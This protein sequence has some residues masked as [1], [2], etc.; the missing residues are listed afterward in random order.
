[1]RDYSTLSYWLETAGDDLTPRPA[2]DR[3]LDADVA[4]LGA[5]F[6]GLWTAYYLLKSRPGL[7]VVVLEKEIAGFGASG[8]NGGWCSSKLN[9][10][11]DVV[12]GRFGTAAAQGL[13]RALFDTVD[14]VGRAC[15]AEG[16]DAAYTKGGSLFV[17]RHPYQI[18]MLHEWSGMHQTFGFGDRQQ[19]L[20]AAAL[21]ERIRIQG[22]IAAWYS[23]D[24][25]SVHPGR[26]VRGL[27]RTVER[28]GGR[29]FERTEVADYRPG[30]GA[31]LSTAGGTVRAGAIV[32]AGE[33]Y[34]TRLRRL[35]R[36]L[37]PIYS[38]IVLTEPLSERQWEAIGWRAR[39]SVASFRL[40]VDYL[41][42]TPDGRIL[43]GGR[44]A[45]Y[46]YG[47]GIADAFDRDP[48]THDML[49]RMALDWFPALEG[50]RFT[51]AWGGPIGV[52]RDWSPTIAFDRRTGLATARG[53]TGHGVAP[54]NLAGRIL[55][56]LIEGRDSEIVRLPIVNHRS[57]SW[58]PEP[59]RW[60]AVRYVQE[61]FARLDGRGERTGRAP[62]GRSLA[63][64]LGRH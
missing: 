19:L 17:A 29:I 21:R 10:G 49:R 4:I 51:H 24:Y 58:E 2:L 55:S 63:E 62:T 32:L 30:P 42:R 1:M 15:A 26:L 28:L 59:L 8:R 31:V 40:T 64:R 14:E 39:E 45:P 9:L 16:I 27:A 25:A 44:G 11:L 54:S 48:R 61:A 41:T 53:Y 12:A 3:D 34:L 50:I 52:P 5:G 38:L 35:H 13:Q 22:G 37:L 57:P 33:A 46:H 47:S 36:Q 20:D 23:P 60:L 56:D 6:T 7:R 18:P 43:F